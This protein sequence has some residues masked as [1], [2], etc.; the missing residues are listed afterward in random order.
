MALA[1][2]SAEQP[3]GVRDRLEWLRRSRYLDRATASFEL[4]ANDTDVLLV[5][6]LLSWQVWAE[7]AYASQPLGFVTRTEGMRRLFGELLPDEICARGS[8]ARFDQAFWSAP[9]REYARSWDG[10]GVPDEWIDPTALANHWRGDRPL[11]NSSVLLQACWLASMD[12]VQ[13]PAEHV[14]G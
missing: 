13:Q 11:A 14:V 2:W 1:D 6:P 3:R 12:G 8:K 4:T 10:T 7:I 9:T 5:H